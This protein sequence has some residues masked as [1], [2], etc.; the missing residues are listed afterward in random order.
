MGPI[1]CRCRETVASEITDARIGNRYSKPSTTPI[2]TAESRT[3]V[4]TPRLSRAMS[5]RYTAT[6]R[7]ARRSAPELRDAYPCSGVKP[8]PGRISRPASADPPTASAE[9]MS[10]GAVSTA[11]LARRSVSRRGTVTSDSLIIPVLYSLP[12]ASTPATAATA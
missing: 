5:V 9:A 6:P 1:C 4:A 12:M 11:A 3:A 2:A 8:R 10:T 7:A